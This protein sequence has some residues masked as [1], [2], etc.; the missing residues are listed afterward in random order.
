MKCLEK[1]RNRRYE[2]ASALAAD[3][4]RHLN[5]EPVL[6]TPPSATYRLKKFIRK[7]RPGVMAL[8]LVL[9]ALAAGVAGIAWEYFEA[10]AQ[11]RFAE[12]G[13]KSADE[14]RQTLRRC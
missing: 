12:S 6:A 14:Q 13:W 3:V 5:D 1:D 7:H 4:L 11:R 8:V 9:A 2:T 10:D